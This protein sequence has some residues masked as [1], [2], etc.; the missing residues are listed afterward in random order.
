MSGL[1]IIVFRIKIAQGIREDLL[2][3]QNFYLIFYDSTGN[4]ELCCGCYFYCKWAFF[5]WP[6][7][8]AKDSVLKDI[9]FFEMVPVV[10]TT[11][12]ANKRLIFRKVNLAW[13]SIINKQTAQSKR[14]M[15]LVSSFVLNCMQCYVLFKAVH[16]DSHAND[17][18][19]SS[20]RIQWQ[21]FHR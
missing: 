18:S 10:L 21:G 16:I 19:D 1:E 4:V 17:I 12:L 3:W 13:V 9:T 11:Q 20:S 2:L 6:L 7:D 5:Q 15:Q 14:V 8:W